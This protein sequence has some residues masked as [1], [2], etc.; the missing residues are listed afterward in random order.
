MA[1]DIMPALKSLSVT[2]KKEKKN[3]KTAI[4][5]MQEVQRREIAR[6]KDIEENIDDILQ[7]IGSL[8]SITSNHAGEIRLMMDRLLKMWE[9]KWYF[10]RSVNLEI[11]MNQPKRCKK[12]I[13]S[14]TP[15]LPSPLRGGGLGWGV[16]GTGGE[17]PSPSKNI[18]FPLC[19]QG[20]K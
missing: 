10:N 14:I 7:A 13:N 4:L 16:K 15:T 3:L 1:G 5:R 19:L 20:C 2:G 17:V 8:L 18:A 12:S 6:K 9:G 11:V